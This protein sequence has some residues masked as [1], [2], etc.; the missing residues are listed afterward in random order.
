MASAYKEPMSKS[1]RDKLR[2]D[3]MPI[4]DNAIARACQ[5]RRQ[6]RSMLSGWGYVRGLEDSARTPWEIDEELLE[7]V[8]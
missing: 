6:A 3:L 5:I 4:L 7:G 2:A 1:K 8:E